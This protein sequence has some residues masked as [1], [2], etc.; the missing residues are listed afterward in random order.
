LTEQQ[1]PRIEWAAFYDGPIASAGP[2]RPRNT[3][4]EFTGAAL[5]V[6]IWT[7]LIVALSGAP[8]T[9]VDLR[10]DMVTPSGQR[11]P[12]PF[13][14]RGR[15]AQNGYLGLTAG[16]GGLALPEYGEYRL[17][18]SLRTDPA[19]QTSVRFR[20]APQAAPGVH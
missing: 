13:P 19:V 20:V 8:G 14:M 1:R 2:E 18:V 10:L 15:I 11:G 6:R 9:P 4:E 7:T 16:L 3:Q 12:A 5:P 17:E